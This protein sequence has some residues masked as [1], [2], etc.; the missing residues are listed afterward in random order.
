ME[1]YIISN[2][3]WFKLH[4]LIRIIIILITNI[5]FMVVVKSEIIESILIKII[6]ILSIPLIVTLLLFD[7][8]QRPVYFELKKIG[9][10]IRIG[11]YIPDTRYLVAFR[12]NKI[13]FLD[14]NQS[15]KIIFDI[16]YYKL[17]LKNTFVVKIQKQDGGLIS[18]RPINFSWAKK[19]DIEKMKELFEN[20]NKKV[21]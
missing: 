3:K 8:I 13:K 9:E 4:L 14:I 11:I 17:S 10:R 19:G 16:N 21:Y 2:S 6:Q 12:K 15:E 18:T 5:V 20:H 7:W 1:N